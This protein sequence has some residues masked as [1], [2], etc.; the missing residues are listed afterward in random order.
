MITAYLVK[1]TDYEGRSVFYGDGKKA[2]LYMDEPS[3]KT[4]A[5]RVTEKGYPANVVLA[6]L[7][8][9]DDYT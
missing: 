2:F 9:A 8:T 4:A 7:H 3:A 6:V 5:D 1:F